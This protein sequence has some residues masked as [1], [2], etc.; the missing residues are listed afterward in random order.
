VADRVAIPAEGL[1]PAGRA[2]MRELLGFGL[3][4]FAHPDDP[5]DPDPTAD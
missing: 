1:R 3:I 5:A 4:D 2:M